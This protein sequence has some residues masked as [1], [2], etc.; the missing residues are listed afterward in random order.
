MVCIVNGKFLLNSEH[1]IF[2]SKP[3]YSDKQAYQ[4]W[5]AMLHRVYYKSQASKSKSYQTLKVCE[6]WF[7]YQNFE[8]WYKKQQKEDNLDKDL[9]SFG[10]SYEYSPDSCLLLP[11]KVNNLMVNIFKPSGKFL[12]GSVLVSTR[13]GTK[14]WKSQISKNGKTEHIGWFYTELE[15]H[16]SWQHEKSLLIKDMIKTLSN[17]KVCYHLNLLA[18]VFSKNV[19]NGIIFKKG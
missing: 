17:E 19:K 8:D 10:D 3:V 4:A 1:L 9:R 12:K 7:C 13:K 14:N 18:D 2:K 6:D 5:K 15:A 16:L 11:K